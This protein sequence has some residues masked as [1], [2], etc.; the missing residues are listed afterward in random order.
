MLNLKK[1]SANLTIKDF[2]NCFQILPGT[3]P[4]LHILDIFLFSPVEL[5]HQLVSRIFYHLAW[6]CPIGKTFKIGVANPAPGVQSSVPSLL[7]E[8]WKF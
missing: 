3:S 2:S 5:T 4:G 1:G 6:V 8:E 7:Q